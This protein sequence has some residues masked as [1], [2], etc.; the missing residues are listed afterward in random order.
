MKYITVKGIK[1][2]IRGNY[3]KLQLVAAYTTFVSKYN[4]TMS[5]EQWLIERGKVYI[6]VKR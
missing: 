4:S 5:F 2:L 6:S 3:T 1:Y